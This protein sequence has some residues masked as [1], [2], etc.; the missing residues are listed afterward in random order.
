MPL[1]KVRTAFNFSLED[2]RVLNLEV[3]VSDADNVKQDISID[4]YGR[5]EKV[6]KEKAAAEA[7]AAAKAA[8]AEA[9][10]AAEDEL[11]ALLAG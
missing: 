6:E 1:G 5:K 3:E 11:D 8:K 9:E 7:A 2:K 10:A 4:V